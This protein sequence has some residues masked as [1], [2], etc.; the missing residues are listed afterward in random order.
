MV[1]RHIEGKLRVFTGDKGER[2]LGKGENFEKVG[3]M[4]KYPFVYCAVLRRGLPFVA[5]FIITCAETT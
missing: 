1:F 5:K 3:E 4:T 2:K